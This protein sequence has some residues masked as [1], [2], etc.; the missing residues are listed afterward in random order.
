M[1]LLARIGLWS[2][3]ALKFFG[4]V[5]M[6]QM[7]D[8]FN[9]KDESSLTGSWQGPHANPF[10]DMKIKAVIGALTLGMGYFAYKSFKK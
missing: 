4:I 10:E 2:Q 6:T 7:Y 5:Q 9:V 1:Y 8:G 3:R